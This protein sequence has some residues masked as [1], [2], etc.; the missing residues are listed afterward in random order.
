L[1]WESEEKINHHLKDKMKNI[2]KGT[3]ELNPRNEDKKI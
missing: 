1:P 2:S 3:Y